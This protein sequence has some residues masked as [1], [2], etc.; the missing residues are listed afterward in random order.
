M[1]QLA[2]AVGEAEKCANVAAQLVSK[3]ARTRS[4]DPQQNGGGSNRVG[5]DNTNIRD[6][7]LIANVR[8]KLVLIPTLFLKIR[9][10]LTFFMMDCFFLNCK[11]YL[12]L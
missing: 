5:K 1:Q 10:Q 11:N 2:M 3:K 6:V 12:V 9:F 7:L 4:V 8:K